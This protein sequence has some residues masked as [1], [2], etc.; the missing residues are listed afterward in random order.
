MR[1]PKCS[2]ISFDDLAVCAKC[3]GDLSVLSGELNGTCIEAKPEFFLGTAIQ[4]PA[5]DEDSFSD[6]QA[7]PPIDHGGINF[8]DTSTGGFSPLS[9]SAAA[10]A[11]SDFDDSVGLS[12]EDDVAIELGDIMPID[13]DQL[14]DTSVFAGA[15]LADT[16][17]FDPANFALDLDKTET[18]RVAGNHD[19]DLDLTGRFASTNLDL[20]LDGDFSD[21][22]IDESGLE[23][24]DDGSPSVS[25]T[26]SEVSSLNSSDG[27]LGSASLDNSVGI[28]LDDELIAQLSS[29][30][31]DL[32][33]TVAFAPNVSGSVPLAGDAAGDAAGGAAGGAAGSLELDDSLTAEL[34]GSF[35]VRESSEAVSLD[36][37]DDQSGSGE[38][39]LDAALV[40]ELA[41]DSSSGEVFED[42]DLDDHGEGAD[43][44]PVPD[45]FAEA[46][47]AVAPIEDLT[48][49]FS[50]ISYSDEPE[51]G[52]L[53]LSEI[54]VTDLIESSSEE[55]TQYVNGSLE[56]DVESRGGVQ[57]FDSSP[58][59][60][61]VKVA[62]DVA[63]LDELASTEIDVSDLIDSSSVEEDLLASTD[64]QILGGPSVD[65]APVSGHMAEQDLVLDEFPVVDVEV[66][67]N[68]GLS[69]MSLSA[70][71]DLDVDVLS[72]D[73]DLFDEVDISELE[74]ELSGSLGVKSKGEDG[75]SEIELFPDADDDEGPPDLPSSYPLA[76]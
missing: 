66:P 70:S 25:G 12:S 40:A 64:E 63:V 55:S 60:F 45:F 68:A 10:S 7:L 41:N 1:C 32:D 65:V 11:V 14:D 50:P 72:E 2:F 43:L 76:K 18:M 16:D 31:D 71:D 19:V 44:G 58:A 17:S 35:S 24:T 59:D 20:E 9:S 30:E 67:G 46:T 57:A 33:S 38:F 21:I 28:D 34:T 13:L 54:D 47:G 3:A 39:E 69:E 74:A 15:A 48:G 53:N 6:S 75:L 73:G 4:T 51:L 37:S 42:V 27:H 36:Y 62:D 29:F 23:F 49:E 56:V 61:P 26:S 52:D 5:I 8:D 22:D